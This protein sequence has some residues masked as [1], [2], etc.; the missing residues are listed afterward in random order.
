MLSPNGIQAILF[1]LDG[2]LRFNRPASFDVFLDYAASL[3]VSDHPELRRQVT[4]W[5]HAYWAMSAELA[6]DSQAF[7]GLNDAFWVN[8]AVRVLSLLGESM[9]CARLLAPEMHRYMK[10]EHRPQDYIPPDVPSTLSLLKEAGFRLGVITNRDEPCDDYLKQVNLLP[11][12]ELS[13]VAGE[14]NA[15]KPD[16]KIFWHALQ[17]LGLKPAQAIYIGDNYYADILGARASG[18]NPVLFDPDRLFPE[19]DC[20]VIA[21]LS[22]L[23]L[24]KEFI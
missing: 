18:I 22:D 1:D 7:G 11:Y 6:Q 4:R 19:A 13:L 2:T 20:P 15:W 9:E 24:I 12:L 14:V 8:Y 5:T 16:P 23:S 3:G 10:E 21:N 17:R